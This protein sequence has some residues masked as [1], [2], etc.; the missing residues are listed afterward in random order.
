VQTFEQFFFEKQAIPPTVRVDIHN[1]GT[2]DAKADTGNDGHNVLHATDIKD[3]G[4]IITFVCNGKQHRAQSQGTM[5]INKGP[6]LQED[7]H[8]IKLD[9]AVNGK[10]YRGEPFT[11]S[12]RSGMTEPVLLSKN[13]I[14]QMNSVVDPSLA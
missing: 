9:V 10:T 8:V 5:T 12:D 11:I 1:I 3:D 7:R 14:A 6:Q 13:F 4:S 2:F